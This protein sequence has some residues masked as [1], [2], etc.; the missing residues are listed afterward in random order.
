MHLLLL[1]LLLQDKARELEIRRATA[2]VLA[3]LADWCGQKKLRVEGRAWC[4]EALLVSPDHPKAKALR[5]KLDGENEADEAAAKE[6]EK[7][8]EAAAKKIAKGYR[9]LAV[10]KHPASENAKYDAYLIRAYELDPKGTEPVFVAEWR[11]AYQK[12]DLERVHRLLSSSERVK[13]DDKHAKVLREVELKIAETKPVLRTAKEHPIQYYLALPKNWSPDKTWPILVTV[14]GAGCNWLGNCNAF[15]GARGDRP[16]ILVTP[17]T[18]CNTNKLEKAKYPGYPQELLDEV[19]RSGRLAWD[20]AGLLAI[21]AEVRKEFAG[22]EKFF[23]TG[24]SGGGNLT[25]RMIFGHPE[26]IAG[27]SP[28]CANFYMTGTISQAPERETVPV[29]A[30][31]GDKDEYLD[32]NPNLNA[33]WASA[34]KHCDDHGFKNVTRVMLPGV[35]HSTCVNEVL[36]FFTELLKK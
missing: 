4:D 30:F 20:E 10:V 22:Q 17:L 9:E 23:I 34:K 36:T 27:A 31:Q 6:Y 25:W 26:K 5:P 11:A 7:K 13:P 16:F 33:Q 2:Q 15:L 28:A 35:G 21:L 1:A 12:K 14:E 29:K 19:D 18:F 32:G 24:F 3:D 8:L